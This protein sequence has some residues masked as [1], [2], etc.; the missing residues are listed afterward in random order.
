MEAIPAWF[1]DRD[2]GQVYDDEFKRARAEA[3][4]L[5]EQHPVAYGGGVVV[6]SLV[7]PATYAPVG[8]VG[9]GAALDKRKEVLLP[10]H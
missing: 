7:Q 8:W 1:E 9:R 5:Q 4:Y 2:A 3:A 6:G 10:A